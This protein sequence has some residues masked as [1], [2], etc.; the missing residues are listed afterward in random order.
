MKQNY[1]FAGLAA[2][3]LTACSSDQVLDENRGDAINFHVAAP[4]STR[5]TPTTTANLTTFKVT[6][7][8]GTKQSFDE[9]ATKNTAGTQWNTAATHYWPQNDSEL[10]FYAYAPASVTATFSDTEKKIKNFSPASAA[11][12]QVDL[13]FAQ[14][15]G[16]KSTNETSGVPL[17]F[18]HALSQIV[19]QAKNAR[20]ADMKVEILGVKLAKIGENATFT[21][22]TTAT[23]AST[24]SGSWTAPTSK[25]FYYIGKENAS[26]AVTVGQ[27]ATNLMF[28]AGSWMLVP[29]QL[30]A[31]NIKADANNNNEGN[32]LSVLCRI[33]QK[34]A[35][36]TYT[37]LYPATAGKFG[38]SAVPINTLWEAGKK[39]TYTLNFFGGNNGGGAGNQDPSNNDPTKDPGTKNPN[40]DET[41]G[42]NPGEP[43]LGAPIFFTV[44]VEDWADGGNADLNL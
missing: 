21:F 22:P 19:V 34:N 16:K 27:N 30:T 12:S 44:T 43:V 35:D 37:Q 10:F 2:L 17:L 14:N 20:H 41:P 9:T 31:W 24:A 7:Y 18:K 4:L 28:G 6:A 15:K 36:N 33:S 40:V 13:V 8:A 5:A 1:L 25:V 23:A 32:Y 38:F 3:A 29:Q 26:E 11:A 42:K 39:Y